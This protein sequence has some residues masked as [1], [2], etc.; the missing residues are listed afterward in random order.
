MGLF[1]LGEIFKI[2]PVSLMVN[3]VRNYANKHVQKIESFSI[4][5]L[6]DTVEYVRFPFDFYVS[7]ALQNVVYF[8]FIVTENITKHPAHSEFQ[9]CPNYCSPVSR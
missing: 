6:Q 9:N 5:K 3:F 7:S 2:F 4:E 1:C 8:T